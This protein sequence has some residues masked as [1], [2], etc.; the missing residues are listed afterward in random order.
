MVSV[1]QDLVS[2]I[3]AKA[4]NMVRKMDIR[5]IGIVENMSYIICLIATKKSE[6]LIVKTQKGF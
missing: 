1:P 5:V 2:M 3:V 4:V 6:Y